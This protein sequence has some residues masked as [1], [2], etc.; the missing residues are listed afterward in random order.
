MDLVECSNCKEINPAGSTTC[1]I[2]A[3]QIASYQDNY[4]RYFFNE[5]FTYKKLINKVDRHAQPFIDL[6]FYSC[7]ILGALFIIYPFYLRS[8]AIFVF[9]FISSLFF[10]A[11]LAFKRQKIS[12]G[13]E[14]V[15]ASSLIYPYF[16]AFLICFSIFVLG[17]LVINDKILSPKVVI[18]F[19]LLIFLFFS[20]IFL[21]LFLNEYPKIKINNQ[22]IVFSRNKL[23][24]P[25]SEIQYIY[26]V[27]Y[28]KAHLP[29][30]K[31]PDARKQLRIQIKPE[32][33]IN[34]KKLPLKDNVLIISWLK[35]SLNLSELLNFVSNQNV[36]AE[37][38]I[39]TVIEVRN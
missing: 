8:T 1:R 19:Y 11:C 28:F 26:S 37:K 15:L 24:I 7:F 2:C 34:Y 39:L 30:R 9:T 12:N 4:E 31:P 18:N 13:Q 10:F 38:R 36:T 22:G 23:L 32:F 17:M 3:A 33:L 20:I 25:W 27:N 6:L 35:Y 14:I 21:A 16:S 29:Y 5:N